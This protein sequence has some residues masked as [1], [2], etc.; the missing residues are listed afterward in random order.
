[1]SSWRRIGPLDRCSGIAVIVIPFCLIQMAQYYRRPNTRAVTY[2]TLRGRRNNAPLSPGARLDS[3]LVEAEAVGEALE[4][5]PP[6]GGE[7]EA[8]APGQLAH[9]LRDE[10]A[11]RRRPAAD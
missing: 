3:H 7:G 1:M 8:L 4:R 2:Q 10:D 6:V 11:P 9:R 5:G